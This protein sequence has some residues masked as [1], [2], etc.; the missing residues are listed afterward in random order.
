ME[1]EVDGRLWIGLGVP[2]V[3][4][5]AKGAAFGSG[6]EI[7]DGRRPA[8]GGGFVTG[9]VVVG[10]DRVEHRQ[11]E[12]GVGIDAAGEKEFAGDVDDF[13]V[14]RGRAVEAAMVSP[15]IRRSAWRVSVSVTSVPPLSSVRVAIGSPG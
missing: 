5:S 4:A 8:E 3:Q 12:M 1:G 11:V 15:S 2:L 10:G 7:H 13:G 6:N 9:V 14:G